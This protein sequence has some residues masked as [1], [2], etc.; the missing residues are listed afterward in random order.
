MTEL[1]QLP[2][3]ISRYLG[4][5]DQLIRE[6][7][8]ARWTLSGIVIATASVS[9]VG[10]AQTFREAPA[11]RHATPPV[12]TQAQTDIGPIVS[13]NL[14]GIDPNGEQLGALAR[15]ALNLVVTG[16]LA[17]GESSGLVVV[18]VN[19]QPE[20]AFSSGDEIL[21]GVRLHAV[22]AE[23]I[24]IARGGRLEVVPLKENE[25]GGGTAIVIA[26]TAD[27]RGITNGTSNLTLASAGNSSSLSLSATS[28]T[29]T[30][31]AGRSAA[32][33]ARRRANF[34]APTGITQ[35]VSTQP[36]LSQ[37]GDG[38]PQLASTS[39]P[40]QPERGAGDAKG[41]S[42]GDSTVPQPAPGGESAE[43]PTPKPGSP[44]PEVPRPAPGTAVPEV[45][46]P[47][48]GAAVDGPPRPAR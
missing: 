5:V 4:I 14:F 12:V 43:V 3:A 29:D 30:R 47:A 24:V 7:K 38:A 18:S 15:S 45:P 34:V 31:R 46:R 36:G 44:V 48:P 39:G 11:P 17:G 26:G 21:P 42:S 27:Q 13:A 6:K 10:R 23:R 40:P 37:I 16:L 9:L 41:P 28:G 1:H 32:N 8:W 25:Q 19:G 2:V 33:R 20:T 22:E 35:A